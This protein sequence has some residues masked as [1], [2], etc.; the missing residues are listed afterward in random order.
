[1]CTS[2]L[3]AFQNPDGGRPVFGWAGVKAGLSEIQLPCGKCPEC[4]QNYYKMWAV[5]GSR[6]LLR[7]SSSVFV[8]LTYSDEHLPAD[9][10]LKKEDVQDFLK[11]L[12]KYFGSSKENPIRQ[13]YCGEYG[14]KTLRPHYHLIIFNCDFADKKKLYIS[15]QGHQVFTSATLERLW[16]YGKS[17]FGFADVGSI[18]YLFKY[19]LK[20][21]T[22]KEK[23]RPLTLDIDGINYDVSHEFIEASRNPGI[24][25]HLRGND[26]L[27]KGYLSNNGVKCP[28]PKYYLEWLRTNDPETFDYISN[29]RFD[30][31]SNQP[32]ESYSR[33]KQKEE[34]QRKNLK[35]GKK[36]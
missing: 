23:K 31:M 15:P 7:W 19:I 12:K 4:L 28:L 17:E 29:L 9:R 6:E 5:R 22:R 25:A 10:S 34:A 32:V 3:K 26:S 18:S 11:R 36:I 14:E 13:I 1:M 24:G 16:P 30:F 2:P 27:K 8:T 21:K 33:R 35:T 20:K